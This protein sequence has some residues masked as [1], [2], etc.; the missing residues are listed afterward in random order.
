MT[1]HI[2]CTWIKTAIIN[3]RAVIIMTALFIYH[4]I[5]SIIKTL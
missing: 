5:L 1:D 3:E 2:D 4:I